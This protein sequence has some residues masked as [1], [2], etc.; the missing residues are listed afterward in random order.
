MLTRVPDVIIQEGF[1]QHC[2]KNS[3]NLWTAIQ[4]MKIKLCNPKN[5]FKKKIH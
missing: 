2:V 3:E 4:A 1:S 5:L